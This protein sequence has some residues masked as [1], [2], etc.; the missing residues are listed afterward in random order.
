[1]PLPPGRVALPLP[2][3]KLVSKVLQAAPAVATRMAPPL[4]R[5]AVIDFADVDPTSRTAI[6]L[7]PDQWRVLT[8]VDGQ[9]PLW[10][11]ARALQAP[12]PPI[13]QVAG[14]LVASGAV[15]IVGRAGLE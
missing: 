8:K 6:Q 7:T 11:I 4:P 15:V 1:V 10:A 2:V 13:C 14:E 9:T 3:G 12:E 5:E